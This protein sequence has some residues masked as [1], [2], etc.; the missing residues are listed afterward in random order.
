MLPGP[1]VGGCGPL[2]VSY[3]DKIILHTQTSVV[4]YKHIIYKVFR[5]RAEPSLY[6]L[7]LNITY[8]KT[9]SLIPQ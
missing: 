4:E 6:L 7:F 2:L 5:S 8:K 9:A 3:A 1:F